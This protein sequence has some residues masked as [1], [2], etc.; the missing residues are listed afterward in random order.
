[1]FLALDDDVDV[2]LGKECVT[3]A[4]GFRLVFEPL[5]APPLAVSDSLFA[6]PSIIAATLGRVYLLLLL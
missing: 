4:A 6:A 1:M 5:V 3:A 2:L